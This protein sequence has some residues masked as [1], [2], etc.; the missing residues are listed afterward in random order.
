MS[1]WTAKAMPLIQFYPY[2]VHWLTDVLFL[3]PFP[4]DPV[5]LSGPSCRAEGVHTEELDNDLGRIFFGLFKPPGF[6]FI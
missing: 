4:N 2:A 3:P 5:E 1:A 6:V